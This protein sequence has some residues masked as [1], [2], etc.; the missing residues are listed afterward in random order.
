MD[1]IYRDH[2]NLSEANLRKLF[3]WRI[4]FKEDYNVEAMNVSKWYRTKKS[5]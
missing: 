5:N 4:K 1:E 3:L 2:K